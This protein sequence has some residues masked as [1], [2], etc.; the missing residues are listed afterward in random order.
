MQSSFW[1]SIMTVQNNKILII[2]PS[3]KGHRYKLYLKRII[4]A[5][6]SANKH[7][8]ILTRSE[9]INILHRDF[10]NQIESVVLAKSRLVNFLI[11]K[12]K[13][14]LWMV[15]YQKLLFLT[16]NNR[17]KNIFINTLDTYFLYLALF[18]F[19][20]LGSN[21]LTGI[22]LAPK[23]RSDQLRGVLNKLKYYMRYFL[24]IRLLKR[25]YLKQILCIDPILSRIFNSDKVVSLS[26]WGGNP[27]PVDRMLSRAKFDI[28]NDERMVL[29]LGSITLRKGIKN[30]LKVAQASHCKTKFIIAGQFDDVAELEIK[31]ASQIPNCL[32]IN[33]I[34][35][36]N[37]INELLAATDLCWLLYSDGAYGSSGVLLQA[38]AVMKR[39][40]ATKQGYL[41]ELVAEY[42]RG[43]LLKEFDVDT[44]VDL[45]KQLAVDTEYGATVNVENQRETLFINTI[46]RAF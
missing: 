6:I 40:V 45:I 46:L 5:T 27:E 23:L 37:E 26:D 1:T 2:E 3:F 30:F 44:V 32:I 12:S 18:G 20:G 28:Q 13:L 24:F 10:G 33:R 42:E 14:F 31:N 25:K 17:N 16:R 15:T 21:S 43:I 4:Q 9:N 38:Q 19:P 36:N 29:L 22:L 11:L 8:L 7:V 34:L 39:V 41:G 35:T